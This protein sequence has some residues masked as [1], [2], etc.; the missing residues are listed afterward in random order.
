MP[1]PEF[2]FL[3]VWCRSLS[4]FLQIFKHLVSISLFF[5][6][7]TFKFDRRLRRL[8]FSVDER[9]KTKKTKK[10]RT[11]SE[12][13]SKLL[14]LLRLPCRSLISEGI[15]DANPNNNNKNKNLSIFVFF[16]FPKKR[17]PVFFHFFQGGVLSYMV[18]VLSQCSSHITHH[19]AGR[20]TRQRRNHREN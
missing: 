19:R 4:F 6:L 15:E 1:W 7:Q 5:F 16:C 14:L 11:T 3:L 2:C 18:F 20:L 9:K 12:D 8:F 17:L 13:A 10:K